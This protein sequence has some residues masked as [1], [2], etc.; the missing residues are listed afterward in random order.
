MQTDVFSPR[1]A[2]STW[3]SFCHQRHAAFS[4]THLTYQAASF[5]RGQTQQQRNVNSQ[6]TNA[7]HPCPQPSQPGGWRQSIHCAFLGKDPVSGK[8]AACEPPTR[9]AFGSPCEP[10]RPSNRWGGFTNFSAAP[11]APLMLHGSDFRLLS[12]A[13]ILFWLRLRMCRC[14]TMPPGKPSNV[15]F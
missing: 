11:R 4:F 15:W 12:D 7:A 1:L 10:A 8:E 3:I 14:R 6:V 5:P 13:W 9:A 2:T